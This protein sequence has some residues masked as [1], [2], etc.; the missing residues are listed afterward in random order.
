[1]LL[2]YTV[3]IGHNIAVG[4]EFDDTQDADDQVVE[5]CESVQA[6]CSGKREAAMLSSVT[7][8]C[9]TVQNMMMNKTRH[10]LHYCH[11]TLL[12]RSH[13]QHDAHTTGCSPSHPFGR[14]L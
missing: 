9:C 2:L 10:D 12:A 7:Q 1:M 14:V 3:V 8:C 11:F 4:R 6:N 5:D 13:A